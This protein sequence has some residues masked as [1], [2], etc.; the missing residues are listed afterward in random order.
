M[1]DGDILAAVSR[2]WLVYNVGDVFTWQ[3]WS[4]GDS[5]PEEGYGQA[6][7]Q[8]CEPLIRCTSFRKRSE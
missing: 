4:T 1:K 3:S 2:T 7:T 5:Y 6:N 8:N